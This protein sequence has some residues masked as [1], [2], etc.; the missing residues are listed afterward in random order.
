MNILIV[1]NLKIALGTVQFGI[2]YGINN[3]LGIPFDEEIKQILSV[4][5]NAGIEVV[6]TAIAYGK[7]EEKIGQYSGS[8]FKVVTKLPEFKKNDEYSYKALS[9]IIAGSVARLCTS[10]LYGVLLHRPSQILEKNGNILYKNLQQLKADGLVDKIGI[11]IY[12]PTELDALGNLNDFD[13]VQAPLNILDRRLVNTGW[14]SRLADNGT[15][16]HVRSV[17][18]QGL[19][20]ASPSKRLSKFAPWATLLSKYDEWLKDTGLTALEACIRFPLSFP[21]ISNVIIGVDNSRHLKEIITAANGDMA[22]VPSDINSDDL[23]L[24]NPLSWL[25]F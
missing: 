17:F 19:L 9:E 14:L 15:E 10:K 1:N 5:K 4:A 8:D 2:P 25:N 3:S 21:E 7:A 12:A 16:I 23:K 6:D 22:P 20:L 11:S 13:I 24:I 18:L